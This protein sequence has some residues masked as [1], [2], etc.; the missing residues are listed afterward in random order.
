MRT[1]IHVEDVGALLASSDASVCGHELLMDE[2]DGMKTRLFAVPPG[3]RAVL[4]PRSNRGLAYLFAA[5]Q[6][7]VEA[8]EQS[9]AVNGIAFF[10]PR[11]GDPAIVTASGSRLVFLEL[12]V[13]L[14]GPDFEEF[15]TCSPKY[16][17]FVSYADCTTY[18]ERIKSPKTTSRTLM[19]EHTFPRLC[20]GSV[21][22]TGDDRVAEHRHPMLEQLFYGLPGN[23]VTVIADDAAAPL[24]EHTLMHI[25]LGSMHGVEVKAPDRLHYIWID[26]FRSKADM[27][28]ITREHRT[29][30]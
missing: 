14:A 24:G 21:E 5:G 23:N 11:H 27:D 10:A 28:W 18:K 6:G 12:A 29:D 22:T 9:F 25:P 30:K 26:L 3:C 1:E 15:E 16:P 7:T 20:V 13:S 17:Y 4:H 19:P 8:S 2:V